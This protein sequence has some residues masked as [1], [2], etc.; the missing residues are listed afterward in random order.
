MIE[1]KQNI[2]LWVF[3]GS[4]S[5]TLVLGVIFFV[6]LMPNLTTGTRIELPKIE[7]S[8][9]PNIEPVTI[10][11]MDTEKLRVQ[12]ELIDLDN[13]EEVL[14]QA[15]DEDYSARIYLRTAHD[16]KYQDVLNVMSSVTAAGFSNVGLVTDPASRGSAP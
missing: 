13:L 12:D 2:L 10:Y 16:A 6:F 5:A 9:A 11:V 7:A 8:V 14:R 1:R 3:L 4:F 15:T